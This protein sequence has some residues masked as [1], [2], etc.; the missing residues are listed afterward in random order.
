MKT[1]LFFCLFTLSSASYATN[2]NKDYKYSE[3]NRVFPPIVTDRYDHLIIRLPGEG[4][5]YILHYNDLMYNHALRRG[6]AVDNVI[7]QKCFL[8][9]PMYEF[10]TNRLKNN[11]YFRGNDLYYMCY[12][13]IKYLEETPRE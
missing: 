12:E 7:G 9:A 4:D 8:F 3:K 5:T 11:P 1:L 2:W 10:C 6:C 13:L